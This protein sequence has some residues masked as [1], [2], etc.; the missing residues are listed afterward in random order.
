MPKIN[1][2][3]IPTRIAEFNGFLNSTSTMLS[4]GTPTRGE[5]LGMTSANV[6][7]WVDYQ[8]QWGPLYSNYQD[9]AQRTT[10]LR[11]QMNNLRDEFDDFATDQ[12]KILSVS[13]DITEAEMITLGFSPKDGVKTAKPVITVSPYTQVRP[14]G[15]TFLEVRNR[16]TQ[17]GSRASLHPDA[18]A[19]QVCYQ[20]GG[21]APAGPEACTASEVFSKALMKWNP[22]NASEGDTIY[23]FF[24]W[25]NTR[26]NK[27]SGPFTKLIKTIIV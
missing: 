26:D 12:R 8:S 1:I 21:D 13:P 23:M 9:K 19:I 18:N 27:K 4:T 22:A 24:R 7:Q 16:V 6:T 20:I 3:K 17:D 10:A 11:N 2:G 5:Q 15:D 25:F 14:L